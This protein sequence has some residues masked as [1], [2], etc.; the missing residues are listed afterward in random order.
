MVIVST[1]KK[2][3]FIDI[4][5]EDFNAYNKKFGK[6]KNLSQSWINL[7]QKNDFIIEGI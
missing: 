3:I 2:S 5:L 4:N 1:N 7:P 6:S